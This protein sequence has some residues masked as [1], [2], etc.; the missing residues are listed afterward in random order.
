ML[1]IIAILLCQALLSSCGGA[2]RL[3]YFQDLKDTAVGGVSEA[4]YSFETRIQKND[5]LWITV[6]GTNLDDLAV[7]NSASGVIEGNNVNP[8]LGA[9]NGSPVLGYVVEADGNIKI[10][11]LGKVKAEGLTRRQLEDIIAVKLSEYTKNPIVNVRYLNYRVTVM[12]AVGHPGTFTIPNERLTILEALGLAGDLTAFGNRNEVLVIREENGNRE[13]G[14]INLKS[15]SIFESPFYYL[16]TNDVVYVA[17]TS[18]ATVA[19]ERTPQY[20]GMAAGILSLIL[21][22]IY[23][24]KN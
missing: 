21:T 11:Y 17:P 12:G 13:F 1:P 15:K 5:Q 3:V 24:T 16:R 8:V 2:K 20:V 4:A 14:R 18:S 19:R 6:G 10:P 23:T 7:L 9:S 22:I